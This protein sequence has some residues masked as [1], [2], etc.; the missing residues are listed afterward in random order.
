MET[1]TTNPHFLDEAGEYLEAHGFRRGESVT[2]P[3]QV[4]YFLNYDKAVEIR[5]NRI[6]FA[7]YHPGDDDRSG[8][9]K[10]YASF[11]GIE[12]LDLFGW[13]LLFHLTGIATIRDM[14][15]GAIQEGVRFSAEDVLKGV[16]RHFRVT[17]DRNAVPENY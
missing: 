10:T 16:F 5:G 11:T 7:M 8:E 1:K 9:F 3:G 13:T 14:I 4:F 6:D 15:K 2:K 12:Q 17:G